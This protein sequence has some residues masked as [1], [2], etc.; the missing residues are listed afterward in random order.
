ME[1]FPDVL[2]AAATAEGLSPDQRA[3]IEAPELRGFWQRLAGTCRRWPRA[4]GRALMPPPRWS[5]RC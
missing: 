4:A 5:G 3:L 2:R 1:N